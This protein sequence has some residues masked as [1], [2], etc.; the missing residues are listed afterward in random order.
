[1][2][3]IRRIDFI[4]TAVQ[5]LRNDSTALRTQEESCYPEN[6]ILEFTF[7]L[8]NSVY[9]TVDGSSLFSSKIKQVV[10]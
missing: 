1:M 6:H 10:Q 7:V 9:L 2:M 8:Q 4:Q 3:K 5:L